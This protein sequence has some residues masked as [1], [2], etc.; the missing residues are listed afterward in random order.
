MAPRDVAALPIGVFDSG[1]GGL[2]VVAALRRRLPA[3]SILYLG[4]TARLPYGTKSQETVLRYTR[5]M[6][7]FLTAR[8]VKAVVVACNTAS[9][10]AVPYLREQADR[11]SEGHLLWG[12]IESGAER[13]AAE[14][15]GKVGV[16]A[17]ESTTRSGAYPAALA[18]LRPELEVL[19]AA[20]PLFVPLVEEGWVDDPVAVQVAERYL[21]PLLASKVDTLLLGCTHY[22]LLMP[23][24]SR[25]AGPEVALIDSASAVAERVAR[26][27]E[28]AG[29]AV[30]SDAAG[31]GSGSGPG[32]G[33]AQAAGTL[34]AFVTDVAEHFGRLAE[35]ILGEPVPLE[36]VDVVEGR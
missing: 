4:D 30:A 36:L 3:E 13:A 7:S 9:S 6:I 11:A 12:V 27:L 19:S 15:A 5:S 29:L 28:A 17:T 20:C 2:T 32:P 18:R 22:P 14:S 10:L 1:V 24:L 16:L 35:A 31:P 26:D 23:V 34:H 21:A 8:R 33:P 25:V